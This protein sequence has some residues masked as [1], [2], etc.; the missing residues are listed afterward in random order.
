MTNKLFIICLLAGL[1]CAYCEYYWLRRGYRS[2]ALVASKCPKPSVP[3]TRPPTDAPQRSNQTRTDSL[4]HWLWS[5][6]A[7]SKDKPATP[8]V[9][10]TFEIHTDPRSVFILIKTLCLIGLTM[11]LIASLKTVPTLLRARRAA[12]KE[13][14]FLSSIPKGDGFGQ[15][16]KLFETSN[17]K[18]A[19]VTTS[20]DKRTSSVR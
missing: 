8:V 19:L 2:L 16:S 7:A 15:Q 14:S 11:K 20:I 3:V 5:M 18:V 10:E 12:T 13:S 17:G 4:V 1:V 6:F 9:C